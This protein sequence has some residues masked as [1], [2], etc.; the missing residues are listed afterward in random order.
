MEKVSTDFMDSIERISTNA[1]AKRQ[2]F[3]SLSLS[4]LKNNIYLKIIIRN[5]KNT[6]YCTTIQ[7]KINL[8]KLCFT[9]H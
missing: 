4:Y 9:N 7:L 6:F 1:K 2:L 8:N 3:L 5:S